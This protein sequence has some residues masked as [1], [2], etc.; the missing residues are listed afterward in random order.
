[1]ILK[2]K[3]INTLMLHQASYL[4]KWDDKVIKCMLELKK[5]KI[6]DKIGVSVQTPEEL[7]KVL[8]CKY[9]EHIQL[10]INI[11]DWRWDNFRKKILQRKKKG[12]FTVH[13]RSPLLQGLILSKDSLKW[14]R[15]NLQNPKKVINWI[16]N[17]VTIFRKKSIIDLSL[18]FVNSIDW[19]DGIVIGVV[20]TKQLM[21]NISVARNSKLSI[22]NLN[23]IKNTRPS[24]TSS[25]L[26]PALWK[27]K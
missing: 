16:D 24:L 18:A 6:I 2:K 3:K 27:N 10:P 8:L 20:T 14:N 19:I 21:E 7:R 23:E 22:E 13:A 25:T 26:N 12:K 11:L 9:V 17:S 15:A 4:S 1:M 5:K